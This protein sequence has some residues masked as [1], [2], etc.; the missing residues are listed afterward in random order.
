MGGGG[1]GWGW[2]GIWEVVVERAVWWGRSGWGGMGSDGHVGPGVEC[3][4]V[5]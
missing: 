5:E 4:Q 1:V 3:G 2:V